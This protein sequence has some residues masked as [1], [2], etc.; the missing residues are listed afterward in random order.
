M[1]S[2]K[3]FLKKLRFPKTTVEQ[4]APDWVFEIEVVG[5]PQSGKS[6]VSEYIVARFREQ[7]VFAQWLSQDLERRGLVGEM[8]VGLSVLKSRKKTNSDETTKN[9]K[10]VSGIFLGIFGV[11]ELMAQTSGH[12][13]VVFEQGPYFTNIIEK[14]WAQTPQEVLQFFFEGTRE[15][16]L[17]IYLAETPEVVKTRGVYPMV[18]E[19]ERLAAIQAKMEELSHR[20]NW[21]RIEGTG[22]L[23]QGEVKEAAWQVA[24]KAY[25]RYLEQP[26]RRPLPYVLD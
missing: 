7:K 3:R 10:K 15:P 1:R 20:E 22:V 6:G 23:T 25:Q 12:S 9:R 26:Q 21:V 17:V 16:N 5:L 13:V 2:S 19:S 24:Q 4:P 11:H 14:Y 18:R 8:R